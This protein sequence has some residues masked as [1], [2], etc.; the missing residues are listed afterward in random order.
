[1][2]VEFPLVYAGD[3]SEADGSESSKV[4]AGGNLSAFVGVMVAS[5]TRSLERLAD[6]VKLVESLT[7][8]LSNTVRLVTVPNPQSLRHLGSLRLHVLGRLIRSEHF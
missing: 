7:C 5:G 6:V 1:M 2:Y 8:S 3:G 4:L